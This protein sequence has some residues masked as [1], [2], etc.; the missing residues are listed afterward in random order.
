M[1]KEERDIGKRDW[2]QKEESRR[3]ICE[4]SRRKTKNADRTLKEGNAG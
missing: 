4:E 1:V 3:V 2:G